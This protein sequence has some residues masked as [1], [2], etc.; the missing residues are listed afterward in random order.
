MGNYYQLLKCFIMTCT[1]NCCC[2]A[3][4]SAQT[5]PT[6]GKFGLMALPY[7][8]D[9]LEPVIS[10]ET[11]QLHHGKH[12][13]TYVTNLNNALPGTP[14][15]GKS[16]EEVVVKA[17]GG[18]FNNAGQTLNHNMYFGQM[19]PPREDNKP[20]R[21]I[22]EAIDRQFG[23]F[24][25]F[26]KEFTQKGTTL[27]GSGWAWLSA[28]KEGNLVITQEPNAGNPLRQGLRPLLCFDV[29]EHAYYVDYRNRRAEHLENIWKIINWDV[30]EKRMCSE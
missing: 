6:E 14:L 1:I 17:E 16:L 13:Q 7:A 20:G 3:D 29:W 30:V 9:A 25:A 11:V 15:E 23:S 22:A 24:E 18:V 26:K 27:F 19:R 21:K 10:K 12:L 28:D 2:L 4:I 5:M 8:E